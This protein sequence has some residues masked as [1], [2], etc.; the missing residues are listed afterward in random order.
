VSDAEL[1]KSEKTFAWMKAHPKAV[2]RWKRDRK[3]KDEIALFSP[4]QT[5]LNPR[6]CPDIVALYIRHLGH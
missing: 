4:S 2:Q 5:R 6:W 3:E 1:E